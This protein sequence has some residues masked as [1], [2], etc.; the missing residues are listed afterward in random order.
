MADLM[1][2]LTLKGKGFGKSNQI[3]TNFGMME[4]ASSP[5]GLSITLNLSDMPGFKVYKT[6]KRPNALTD[7]FLWIANENGVSEPYGPFKITI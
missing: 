7:M 2:P 5:D 4:A 3:Y 1:A 6:V